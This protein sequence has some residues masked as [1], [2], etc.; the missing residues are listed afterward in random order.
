MEQAVA[1]LRSG[2]ASD[3]RKVEAIVQ[4]VYSLAEMIPVRLLNLREE[5]L[6]HNGIL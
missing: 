4:L 3:V 1:E 6:H 2:R 5:G